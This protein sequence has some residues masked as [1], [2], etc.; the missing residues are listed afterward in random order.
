MKNKNCDICQ[1]K[2][3]L[4][5]K[6]LF[7]NKYGLFVLNAIP[8]IKIKGKNFKVKKRFSVSIHDHIKKPSPYLLKMV[9][10]LLKNFSKKNIH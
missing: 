5:D 4:R 3:L 7:E 2:H 10:K 6:F 1:R 8:F 9:K